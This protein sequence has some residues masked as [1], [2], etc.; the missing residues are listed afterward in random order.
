MVLG[1]H[2]PCATDGPKGL[3]KDS[4][5]VENVHLPPQKW[6]SLKGKWDL[7]WRTAPLCHSR[8]SV[9]W[10]IF[11]SVLCVAEAGSQA[12]PPCLLPRGLFAFPCSQPGFQLFPGF[13]QQAWGCSGS[14]SC[15]GLPPLLFCPSVLACHGNRL[16]LPLGPFFSACSAGTPAHLS[17]SAHLP[18]LSSQ[19]RLVLVSCTRE[20]K[21][22]S[23]F[24]IS[25]SEPKTDWNVAAWIL[26]CCF[27]M[28]WL[29]DLPLFIIKLIP[30]VTVQW[31]HILFEIFVWSSLKLFKKQLHKTKWEL[32]IYNLQC[33]STT[34]FSFG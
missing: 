4:M 7:L 27:F 30:Q 11:W 16:L 26:K 32:L 18:V 6:G 14:R 29:C 33:H 31:I 19:D 2:I 12:G 5:P 34:G 10:Q 21:E 25:G 24:S 17:G 20:Q 23:F 9:H 1:T 8:V 13:P 3:Q 15:S 22:P 28:T